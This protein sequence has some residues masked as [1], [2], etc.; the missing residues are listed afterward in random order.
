MSKEFEEKK[1]LILGGN[2]ETI[3][4]VEIANSWGIKTIVAS[5]RHADPAKA[6]AW[7]AYDF[8]GLDVGAVIKIATDEKIDGVLVGVADIL[9]P[10]YCKVCEALDLPCYATQEI[11]DVFSFKDVFK[12]TCERY[13]VHGIPEYYLDSEMKREDLDKIV[14]PVMVKPVDNGGGVGMTVAYNEK[15]LRKAVSVALEHSHKRRF[16]VERYMECEDVGIY[17]TFK[18]GECSVSCVY[19]RYTTDKQP[20]LSRVNLC[21]IYPSKHLDDYY[22]RMH[23][24]AV[25]MF[26]EIGIKN[27]VLLISAFYEDGEFYVYDPGFR[28]QGE[29][30]HLLMKAIHGFDQREMLIRFAL[31]GSGGNINLKVE[32]DVAFRGKSAAT[33]WVLLKQGTIKTIKGFENIEN[34]RRIVANVQRLQEG[35]TVEASWIGNEKQVLT[36]LYMVC[37][38]KEELA[39]CIREYEQKIKVIDDKGNDMI[40]EWMDPDIVI[41]NRERKRTAVITGGTSGIGYETAKH[42]LNEGYNVAIIGR[43]S[44]RAKNAEKNLGMHC[45]SYCCDVSNVGQIE[46]TLDN[47]HRDFGSIDVLVNCAGV[48]DTSKIDTLTEQEW[49][50]VININLKGTYFMIQKAIP[51]LEKGIAPRIINIGSNAGRMGG[52]ENGLAYT[53]S[54]GGVIALTYGAARRLAPKG[55]TV[56]CVAPGTIVTEMSENGYSESTRQ[57]LIRRF[58][59]GRMG[60]P[61]EVAAAVS[62]FAG[63]DSSFTTGAVLDINGGMFMG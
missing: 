36:R 32:D 29:A 47:I 25:R 24:N 1:L 12:S 11:V 62:Y 45:K 26:K 51:Y 17:Y 44:N 9:V 60:R 4:L 22:K 19:D 5:A 48:L 54:K 23:K 52:F 58:P 6:Y 49:D 38:T 13:G 53:A 15:E 59:L 61:E 35:M 28:L 20:G 33:F 3:P 63:K 39:Q 10:M 57:K 43:N 18:D 46:E 7:K 40:L 30:P 16:I 31:T 55:I 50:K 37:D 27:G 8:E 2:P 41:C 21:S 56:N 14:Y 42:L 34:D